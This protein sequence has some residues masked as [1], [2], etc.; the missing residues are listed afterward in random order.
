VHHRTL[1]PF[2]DAA[3]CAYG[4]CT[5]SEPPSC[6]ALLVGE[7]AGGTAVVHD[8]AFGRNVRATAPVATSEFRSTIVPRFGPAYENEHRGFW[9]DPFDLLRIHRKAEEQGLDVIGSIHLHPDWHRIGPPAERGLRISQAPTPMDVYM[10]D[11]SQ[12]PVNMI[13]YLERPDDELCYVFGAWSPPADSNSD[14]PPID[15]Q[16]RFFK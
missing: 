6:F 5:P 10:F 16:F 15:I 7:V 2:L 4:R 12:W 1:E 9:C 14:C 3:T 11:N 8:V 13:C